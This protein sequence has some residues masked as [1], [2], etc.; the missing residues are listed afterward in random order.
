[1]AQTAIE[2]DCSGNRSVFTFSATT[3]PVLLTSRP[4]VGKM[5]S[6]TLVEPMSGGSFNI[7]KQLSTPFVE[8]VAKAHWKFQNAPWKFE[9]ERKVPEVGDVRNLECEFPGL[10][11]VKVSE[12]LRKYINSDSYYEHE[13]YLTESNMLPEVEGYI[14]SFMLFSDVE[15]P[16][17]SFVAYRAT[18]NKGKVSDS[19]KAAFKRSIDAMEDPTPTMPLTPVSFRSGCSFYMTKHLSV[20]LAKAAAKAHW[21]FQNV[22]WKFEPEREFPEVGDVRNLECELPG[23]GVV[24]VSETL[25]KFINTESY[26]EH[27]YFCITE[28]SMLPEVEGYIGNIRV[29]SDAECPGKSFVA[30]RA[31][32]IKVEVS[33][34]FKDACK[35]AIDA[36]D[37]P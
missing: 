4:K 15:C 27:E 33:D 32:W 21:K 26:Y 6:K 24:N 9:P 22:P 16:E 31:T 1:M 23:L 12:T 28:S 13:Y 8:A 18:W 5:A 3:A 7:T 34:W 11:V 35:G 30:Y 2:M 20:P 29:F 17:K 37:A 19:I 10:G 36:F 14:G 25:K